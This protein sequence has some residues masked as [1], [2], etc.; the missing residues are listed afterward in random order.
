MGVQFCQ[1]SP[2]DH[3]EFEPSEWYNIPDDNGFADFIDINR[4]TL[5]GFVD[6]AH[7]NDLRRRCS[8]TGLVFTFCGGAVFWRL[9]TQSLTACSST[10]S[11]FFA[12][13]KAGKVYRFLRMVI[14][15]LGY[16]QSCPTSI[17]IDN[18]PALQMINENTAPTEN[19]RH[20]DIRYWALQDWVREDKIL[21]MRHCA[22]IRNIADDLTKLLGYVLHSRHCHRLMGHYT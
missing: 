18:L 10:E 4:P 20:V 11:E 1:S 6:A 7:A 19:C 17:Y 12:A 15:Q 3:P 14:K 5:I 16:K 22:G 9:K 13:Y 2:L 8:T 21:I